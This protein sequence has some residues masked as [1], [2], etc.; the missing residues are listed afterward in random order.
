MVG[1]AD[2][3]CTW[4]NGPASR[5][6]H[7]AVLRVP[8][9]ITHNNRLLLY[10]FF[11]TLAIFAPFCVP[12]VVTF[13]VSSYWVRHGFSLTDDPLFAR[14][15][16]TNESNVLTR[17]SVSLAEADQIVCVQTYRGSARPPRCRKYSTVR[18]GGQRIWLAPP[19][20]FLAKISGN[21][22]PY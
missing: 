21:E 9:I 5:C 18:D 15:P 14:T 19:G 17:P 8:P 1:N 12:V 16:I 20:L 22:K 10:F 3:A 7:C 4:R 13:H 11:P 6:R 2:R